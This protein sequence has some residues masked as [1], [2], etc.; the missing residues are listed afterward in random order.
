M[1]MGI[2]VHM[3]LLRRGDVKTLSHSLRSFVK[4]ISNSASTNERSECL[5]VSTPKRIT[6]LLIN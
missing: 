5:H 6:N 4:T 3:L 2:F 1:P